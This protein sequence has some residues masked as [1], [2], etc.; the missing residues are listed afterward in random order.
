MRSAIK[1]FFVLC[2]VIG[3]FS[4]LIIG[5]AVSPTQYIYKKTKFFSYWFP[6]EIYDFDAIGHGRDYDAIHIFKLSEFDGN[7]FFLFLQ[8]KDN[9]SA[10][11]VNIDE[12]EYELC[13]V[14]FDYHIRDMLFAEDGYWT[15]YPENK[16]FC[17][18]DSANRLLYIRT[19]SSFIGYK[20]N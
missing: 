8:E 3:I 18:Y 6:K 9:W 16:L 20:R 12:K 14:E 7:R 11:P 2:L 4:I 19:A 13:D 1:K 15:I 10:L 5:W 17:V